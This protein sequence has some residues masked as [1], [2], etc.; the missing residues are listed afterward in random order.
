MHI[1]LFDKGY[2]KEISFNIYTLNFFLNIFSCLLVI[3]G[4][5]TPRFNYDINYMNKFLL[6]TLY[7]D[8]VSLHM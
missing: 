5:V 1:W 2:V 8:N 3:C 7:D 6:I 4:I